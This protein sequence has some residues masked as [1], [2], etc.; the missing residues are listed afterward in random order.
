MKS[1]ATFVKLKYP[2]K[3]NG[4]YSHIMQD[5]VLYITKDDV[6][7]KLDSNEIMDM[8][9]TLGIG[10]DFKNGYHEEQ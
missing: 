7:I 3:S 9:S 10:G 8:L 5:S 4:G 2:N 6:K 1:K